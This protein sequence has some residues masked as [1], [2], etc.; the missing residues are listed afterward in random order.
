MNVNSKQFTVCS[1]KMAIT[2]DCKPPTA[3]QNEVIG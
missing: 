2:A 3:N 1:K